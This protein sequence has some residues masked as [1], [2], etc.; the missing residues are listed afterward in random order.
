VPARGAERLHAGVLVVVVGDQQRRVAPLVAAVHDPAIRGHK[1]PHARRVAPANRVEQF[2]AGVHVV[3]PNLVGYRKP[4]PSRIVSA[5]RWPGTT[6]SPKRYPTAN[7][8]TLPCTARVGPRR[9]ASPTSP[10]RRAR[11]SAY[12]APP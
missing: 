2:G 3:P 5:Q 9:S 1:G 11:S 6:P 12:Q 8:V 10:P 7:S 4:I